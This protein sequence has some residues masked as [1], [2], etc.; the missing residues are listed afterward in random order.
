MQCKMCQMLNLKCKSCNR[1]FSSTCITHWAS[2]QQHSVLMKA[3]LIN[4][5]LVAVHSWFGH[6]DFHLRPQTDS[7]LLRL[8]THSQQP[9]SERAVHLALS[10][11]SSTPELPQDC[12]FPCY[13]RVSTVWSVCG[14][15]KVKGNEWKEEARGL[16][17][18]DSICV[19]HFCFN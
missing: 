5:C 14:T 4:S 3:C 16:A 11:T 9:A 8:P 17:M 10:R 6:P 1:Q 19:G 13:P 18:Y 2:P 15:L 12:S 7:L